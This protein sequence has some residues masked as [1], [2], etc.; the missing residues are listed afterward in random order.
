MNQMPASGDVAGTAALAIGSA[1]HHRA[2]RQRATAQRERARDANRNPRAE[3]WRFAA[4]CCM[5]RV[6]ARTV[7][8]GAVVAAGRVRSRHLA[9]RNASRRSA[10]RSLGLPLE[11]GDGRCETERSRR[12]AVANVQRRRAACRRAR[13]AIRR[14]RKQPRGAARGRRAASITW[15]AAWTNLCRSRR[16]NLAGAHVGR[17]GSISVNANVPAG[18]LKHGRLNGSRHRAALQP[19]ALSTP[20]VDGAWRRTWPAGE[21]DRSPCR[22]APSTACTYTDASGIIDA[23]SQRCRG[24]KTAP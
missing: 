18:D 17:A 14:C 2:S 1:R 10:L 15:S 11:S 16:A 5:S 6:R 3:R 9:H 24:L 7:A 13:A 21:R 20:N 22:P 8:G 19:K 12:L 4:A 23:G